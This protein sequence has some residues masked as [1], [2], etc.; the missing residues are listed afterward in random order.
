MIQCIRIIGSSIEI[1]NINLCSTTSREYHQT[2]FPCHNFC[3]LRTAASLVGRIPRFG[4]VYAGCPPLAPLPRA[5]CQLR[6]CIGLTLHR[7]SSTT[8]SAGT[9][10]PHC[11]YSASYLLA[12]FCASAVTDPPYTDCHPTAPRLLCS[13]SDGLEWS[14]SCAASDASPL[15]TLLYFSLALRPQT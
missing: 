4:W 8:L 2:Y 12:L 9:L 1:V 15:A 13:W 3:L 6:L 7:E 14:S 11:C 5:H 10:F